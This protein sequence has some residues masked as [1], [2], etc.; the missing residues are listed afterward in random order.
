[1]RPDGGVV[2]MFDALVFVVAA[3]VALGLSEAV[4]RL[5]IRGNVIDVPN[6]RSSHRVPTPRGGG[7][8]IAIVSMMGVVL[9][10]L[11]GKV[12]LWVL[13]GFCIPGATIAV[14][15]LL[16]DVMQLPA[17]IR[18]IV[19][20]VACAIG[21]WA[22][23]TLEFAGLPVRAVPLAVLVS[24]LLLVLVWGVNLF[25]FMDGIDGI[26]AMEAVFVGL[27]IGVLSYSADASMSHLPA[28]IVAGAAAGFLI[29]NWPPAKIFM[30]DS[31]SGFLGYALCFCGFAAAYAGVN[32]WAF[33]IVVGAFVADATVTLIRR[34]IQGQ[35]VLQPHRSHAY[36][37]LTDRFG[38][39]LPVTLL[40]TGVNVGWLAPLALLAQRWTD[41]AGLI[42]LIAYMPLIVGVTIVRSSSLVRVEV[43]R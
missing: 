37:K 17:S 14:I 16:D 31:G 9:L 22:L 1:M 2:S 38:G 30:G 40:F 20:V 4:R 5:A 8:A 19:H 21:L 34:L 42:A 13:L 12:P 35:Q 26:A 3:I 27:M 25:N 33:V 18:L 32:I 10:W 6:D 39:H 11:V 43:R 28:V 23:P 24:L 15:G 29:L 41:W 7:L 36:Q